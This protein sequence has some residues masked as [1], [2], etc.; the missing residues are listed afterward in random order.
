MAR[1]KVRVRG[2]L[3]KW[4]GAGTGSKYIWLRVSPVDNGSGISNSIP[5]VSRGLLLESASSR[6]DAT[7]ERG[8]TQGA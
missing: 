2:S 5:E 6:V 8:R 4:L 1:R 7:M 3:E